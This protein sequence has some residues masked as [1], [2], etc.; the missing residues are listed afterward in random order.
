MKV[1]SLRDGKEAIIR[2]AKKEDAKLMIDFYNLTGGETDFLSFG[3]NEF[4]K[5]LIEYGNFIEDVSK[6]VNSKIV[7]VTIDKEIVSIAS[8]NSNHKLRS[9]HVGVLGIVVQKHY[10][11][12]GLGGMLMEFLIDWAKSN[13]ITRKISLVTREDN[14]RAIELYK[15]VGFIEEGKLIMDN[16][17]DGVYYNTIM[18]G[19]II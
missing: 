10:C 12:L 5:D 16:Y 19:L 1:I 13:G 17:I 4:K 7:L 8:I 11:G 2:E 15:K 3:E 9:K 18:M 14:I 6:E